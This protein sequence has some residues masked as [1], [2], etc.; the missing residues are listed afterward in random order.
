[1]QSVPKELYQFLPVKVG[2]IRKMYEHRNWYFLKHICARL[3]RVK[4]LVPK[5]S[6]TLPI[7]QIFFDPY[8]HNSIVPDHLF[9][10]HCRKLIEISISE[11]NIGYMQIYLQVATYMPIKDLGACSH[12]TVL[13]CKPKMI[14]DV[15]DFS[16]Y[17]MVMTESLLVPFIAFPRVISV[18]E[19]PL[20]FSKLIYLKI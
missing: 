8:L 1:M 6:Q 17:C 2:P 5:T 13:N 15:P 19:I 20:I 9:A 14:N 7:G 11:S 10:G 12:S 16:V 18:P 4:H 3:S